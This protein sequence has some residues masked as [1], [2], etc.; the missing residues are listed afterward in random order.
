MTTSF[1]ECVLRYFGRIAD[2]QKLASIDLKP[3]AVS[4]KN[5]SITLAI[6][7]DDKR[8]FGLSVRFQ[9]ELPNEISDSFTLEEFLGMVGDSNAN[10]VENVIVSKDSDIPIVLERLANI[11]DQ[12]SLELFEECPRTYTNVLQFRQNRSKLL[13]D[14]LELRNARLSAAVAW[15]NKDYAEFVRLLASV[16]NMLSDAEVEKIRYARSRI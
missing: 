12:H 5:G 13:D 15:K 8:S 14:E 6:F 2:K 9:L 16:E 11:V 7:Y 4:F 3:S 1:N 10:W